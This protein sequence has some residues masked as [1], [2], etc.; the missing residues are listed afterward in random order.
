M[1]DEISTGMTPSTH[2]Y[3]EVK[4]NITESL[5]T[6]EWKPGEVIPS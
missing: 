5:R 3:K 1:T 2:L 6:G 4:H